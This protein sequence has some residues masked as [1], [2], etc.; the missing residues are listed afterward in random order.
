MR[1]SNTSKTTPRLEPLLCVTCNAPLV[2]I[3][4]P[5]LVCGS[6]GATNVVP[7]VYREEVQ[8]LRGLNLATREAAAQWLRMARIRVPR[9][10]F[11]VDAITPFVLMTGVLTILLIAALLHV[12][13]S[14]AL[15]GRLAFLWI[16]LIPAQLFAANVTMRN[17][18]VS[19][20]SDVGAAFAA[21]PPSAPGEPPSCRQC[22][23]ALL[24][25]PDDVAVRCKFCET[26]SIVLFDRLTMETLRTR[27]ATAR[28]SLMEAMKALN[29]H[30]QLKSL[31]TLGRSGVIAGL[32]VLPLIWSFVASWNSS[33]WGLLIALDVYVLAMC[34]FWNLREAF[35]P[36]VSID[37]LDAMLGNRSDARKPRAPG[38]R[39]W[40]DNSSDRMN[41][42][43]PLLVTLIFVAIQILVLRAK[44]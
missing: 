18:L 19:S 36:P 42:I 32:V 31:Q 38:T 16:I 5:S 15:P 9:R 25:Q 24:V 41:Y 44:G 26:E 33:Y 39:G 2:V 21:R 7:K 1:R 8:L 10:R 27:V 37:E 40:Y 22:G 13:S 34:L 14:P 3:D 28:A 4:A 20:V 29:K 23:A 6:C 43:V 11:I 12:V 35:L 30:A 17:M